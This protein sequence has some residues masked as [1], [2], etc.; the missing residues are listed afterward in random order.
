MKQ[1]TNGSR[2]SMCIKAIFQKLKTAPIKHVLAFALV[3]AL[4]CLGEY[5]VSNSLRF[6]TADFRETSLDLNQASLRG[7]ATRNEAGE[8]QLQSGASVTFLDVGEEIINVAVTLE[9][10]D[11]QVLNVTVSTSDEANR[12]AYRTY[13]DLDVYTDE[14]AYFRIRS[15]GKVQALRITLNDGAGALLTAVSL[16]QTPP[17]RF[18]ILRV[19]LVFLL[20]L[21][22]W[23]VWRFRLWKVTY[24]RNNFHHTAVL[25][26]V[27][28]VCIIAFSLCGVFGAGGQKYPFEDTQHLN[29][30]E[31]LF[32]ALM[33]GKT[34]ID[35]DFD[36]S[37]LESMENPYDYTQRK[38]VYAQN[39]HGIFNGTWDRAYYDGNFYCYFGIAPVLLF[40][41]PVYFLTGYVPNATLTVLFICIIGAAAFFGLLLKMIRYFK[42]RVPL[43]ILCIGYPV[44]LLGSLLPMIALCADMYY[45]AVAC[46]ISFCAL[47]AFLAFAALCCEHF[48]WRR[49]LFALS[50]ITLAVTLASRPTVVLYAAVLIPPF[51]AVLAEKGRAISKKLIDAASFLLPLLLAVIPV[52]W[53]NAVRFDSPFEFGATYQLTFSDISYNRL[54]F[55]LLGETFFHYFLQFPQINGLFPYLRPAHLALDSYGTYFYSV[56][57]VGALMFPLAWMGC[58]QT[59]TTK[60]QPVKKATYLLLLLLPFAVA[61][62][63]L[64]LGGVNIR[65]LSDILF[66]LILLGLLVLAELQGKANER[67]SDSSS[68]RIF[69]LAFA[70]LALTALVAFFLLFANERDSIYNQSPSVF[71][72]FANLFS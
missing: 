1:R 31:Q 40:M 38:E 54:S 30:Y 45:L 2:I 63:N 4:L 57:S 26:A 65:Y 46:G 67:L 71:R 55:A 12:N 6:E 66:P 44:L 49:V 9:S 61:F 37:I 33:Q 58:G 35:V 7:K 72:F 70:I 62:A 43:L 41:F 14:T 27:L 18:S 10:V 60:K 69:L 3:L 42:L 36:T 50:G 68:Y 29:A 64:C 56:G 21:G 19:S 52:L 51:L 28:M 13:V 11:L 47:T 15:F 17:T 22:L 32:H 23:L 8:I 39:G 24:D 16:N 25:T 34:E 20:I 5:F 53:Y 59:L 48:L